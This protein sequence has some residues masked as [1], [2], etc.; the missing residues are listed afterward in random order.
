[1]GG[2]YDI[3]EMVK[4]IDFQ[5]MLDSEGIEHNLATIQSK[6]YLKKLMPSFDTLESIERILLMNGIDFRTIKHGADIAAGRLTEFLTLPE[7]FNN[8]VLSQTKLLTNNEGQYWFACLPLDK[9]I[10]LGALAKHLNI[11]SG[12]DLAFADERTL[13]S[14]TGC[15]E[16]N[17]NFFSILNVRRDLDMTVLFDKDLF[18]AD[19]IWAH[20]MD[21]SASTVV[22]KDGVNRIL[23]LTGRS[24]KNLKV[25]NFDDLD[26]QMAT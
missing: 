8:V 15:N 7:E 22:N 6:A 17:A 25:L 24:D 23:E 16:S 2:I 14:Q 4:S 11:N 20:P 21:N 9:E 19:W 5:Q 10:D 13:R 26:L 3:A 18:Q 12:N 1:M